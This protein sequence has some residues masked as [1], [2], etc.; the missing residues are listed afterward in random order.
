MLI[1]NIYFITYLGLQSIVP[2]L[3]PASFNRIV[4]ETC[5]LFIKK[6]RTKEILMMIQVYFKLLNTNMF[7]IHPKT[8]FKRKEK[9]KLKS[10]VALLYYLKF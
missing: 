7:A 4:L 3:W 2:P 10:D 5:K 6:C 9:I 1:Y 8:S